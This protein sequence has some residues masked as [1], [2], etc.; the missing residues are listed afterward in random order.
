M[1][2]C[3][4]IDDEPH[5]IDVL[6]KYIKRTPELQ[7]LGSE[8]D[9]LKGLTAVQNLLPDVTFLDIDMPNLNGLE[10]SNLLNGKTMIVFTTA[11]ATHAIDAYTRNAADYL[12]KPIAYER[13]LLSIV[14]LRERKNLVRKPENQQSY[15]FIQS[16]TKS[17]IVRINFDDIFYV[18]SLN[19]YVIIYHGNEKTIAY[20][21]L[22]E[23]NLLLP[24]NRFSRV[25]KSFVVNN[26][27]IR[28]IEGN[29]ITLSGKPEAAIFIGNTYKADFLNTVQGLSIKRNL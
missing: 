17:R 3:F 11:S 14:R 18:E 23:L 22:K 9:S 25:H 15:F 26:H 21:T 20:V 28:S 29:K 19:N 2:T 7:I 4:V 12:L 24:A 27:K 1:L 13:F 16:E 5:A 6:T 8:E 10:L